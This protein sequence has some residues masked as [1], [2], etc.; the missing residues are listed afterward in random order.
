M[1][2]AYFTSIAALAASVVA[3]PT[4][5]QVSQTLGS[6][7]SVVGGSSAATTTAPATKPSGA[8]G[9]SGATG[10]LLEN[11]GPEVNQVLE[12]TGPNAK[13]L[14]I[15]LSPNVASLLS[16]LGLPGLGG[17]VGSIVASASSLGDLVSGLGPNVQGLLT[18]VGEGG[19]YLLIQL[20]P[21][22][23]GL[24]SG[25]GLPGVGTPVGSVLSTVGQNLKRQ[26]D[27]I[28]GD[29]SPQVQDI[30]EV[31]GTDSKRLLVQ[32]SPEVAALVSGLGLPNVGQPLG[33]VVEQASTVGELVNHTGAPLNQLLTV[34]GDDGQALLIRLSGPVASLLVGLGLPGPGAAVGNVVS[35]VGQNL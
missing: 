5:G 7:T 22:V 26:Q 29:A 20:S 25:L 18:A 16:S 9:A 2:A 10:Q 15:Q 8:S 14:L 11:L 4:G 3:A 35:T 23:A 34:V 6:V 13:R 31:T 33:Q 30:V 19:E 27:D 28:T 32:L 24:V 21:A 1:K 12:V 17:P